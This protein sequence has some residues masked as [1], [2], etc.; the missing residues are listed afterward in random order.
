VDETTERP[1]A[2]PPVDDGGT[3]DATADAPEATA[4]ATLTAADAPSPAPAPRK[5]SSSSEP[6]YWATGRRKTAVARVRLRRGTGQVLV[7]GRT[8]ESFFPVEQRAREAL[9]P[10]VVTE[11]SGQFDIWANV[12]GGGLTGQSG[13][14]SLG[15]ARALRAYEL[16]HDKTLRDSGLLTRDA[17]MAERK[18]YG[19]R[20]ARRR[21]QF[22][23]R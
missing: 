10:L 20:G 13:A 7:N 15:I 18:K 5:A 14:V 9:A 1:Q 21:F 3:T 23:K 2:T 22:S 6:I 8:V 16:S 19:R 11:T 17:R 4:D 12:R